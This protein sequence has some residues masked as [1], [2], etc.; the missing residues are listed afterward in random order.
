MDPHRL[1]G[2]NNSVIPILWNILGVPDSML[3][4]F[5]DFLLRATKFSAQFSKTSIFEKNHLIHLSG[6]KMCHVSAN[7]KKNVSW[8]EHKFICP[9][10]W[11]LVRRK[12]LPAE[13]IYK[14]AP[15]GS[16]NWPQIKISIWLSPVRCFQLLDKKNP[17]WLNWV[18]KRKS[19]FIISN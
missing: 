10:Y 14:T 3:K 17:L 13:I 2:M 12:P 5:W 4:K 11:I 16:K 15:I 1:W 8:P 6:Q 7:Q 18:L 9:Y 19:T